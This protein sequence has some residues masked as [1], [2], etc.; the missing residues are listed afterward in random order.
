[1]SYLDAIILAIVEGLT[2]FLPVSSTGHMIVTTALLGIQPTAFTT[3][4]TVA[5]QLGAILSVVILYWKRFFKSFDFYI[6]LFVAFLPAAI[7][8]F[9]AGDKIDALLERVD[10]VAYA[11]I[12]G[13]IFF[14]LVD[15]MFHDAEEKGSSEVTTKNALVV[16]LFQ[17]IALVPGVSRSAATII[18][19]LSQKLSKTTAAEFSFFLAVPT[20]AAATGYKLLKFILDGGEFSSN[21]IGILA[22]GNV[23]AFIVALIAIRSFISF[24]TKHGFRWFGY[25]RIA[26]GVVIL[27]L[28]YFY[29]GLAIA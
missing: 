25:Y 10:V 8:G 16:G 11:L 15:K 20:M 7:V 13:G 24:L 2:E 12:A 1:M 27:I 29:G 17:L 18:G 4:F 14:L 26:V 21:E 9:L 28:Y 5:I 6:K 22:V 3:T 23:V 19:G